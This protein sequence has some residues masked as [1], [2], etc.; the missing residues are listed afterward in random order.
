MNQTH[1]DLYNEVPNVHNGR[2]LALE[3]KAKARTEEM[4]FLAR[5][6]TAYTCDLVKNCLTRVGS[7][8]KKG[9]GLGQTNVT[10]SGHEYGH[11][12]AWLKFAS[13]PDS[14]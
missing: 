1:P 3:R 7:R 13:T 10:T 4:D 8:S 14:I 12:C 9:L 5:D 6:L 11:G 2:V